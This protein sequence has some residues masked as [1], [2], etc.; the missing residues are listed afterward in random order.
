MDAGMDTGR[1]L[2]LDKRLGPEQRQWQGGEMQEMFR[3][4]Y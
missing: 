4:Y 2:R 1:E 3:K